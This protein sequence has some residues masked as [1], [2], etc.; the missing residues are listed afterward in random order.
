MPTRH[1][2]R[3]FRPVQSLY[4]ATLALV[5]TVEFLVMDVRYPLLIRFP[6]IT[7]RSKAHTTFIELFV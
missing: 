4:V 6:I 5:A 2:G 3:P 1:T 7:Q